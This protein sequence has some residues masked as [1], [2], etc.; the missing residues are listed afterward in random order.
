MQNPTSKT[1]IT[2]L[3][4]EAASANPFALFFFLFQLNFLAWLVAGAVMATVSPD[5]VQ[6]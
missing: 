1:L 4:K 6:E 2:F 3:Q 5:V